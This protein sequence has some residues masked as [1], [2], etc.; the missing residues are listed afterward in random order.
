MPGGQSSCGDGGLDTGSRKCPVRDH[1]IAIREHIRAALLGALVRERLAC[2][3]GIER[4]D[5]ARETGDDVARSEGFRAYQ[6]L[7]AHGTDSASTRP[8]QA[9]G[10]DAPVAPE[11]R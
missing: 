4:L 8:V 11:E 5:T 7:I 2:E 6:W 10:W 9:P 3:I 1:P